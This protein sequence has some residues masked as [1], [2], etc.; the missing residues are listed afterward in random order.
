VV[1][2]VMVWTCAVL[3][4]ATLTPDDKDMSPNL[5]N[6]IACHLPQEYSRPL[7]GI[8]LEGSDTWS[9]GFKVENTSSAGRVSVYTE[10]S[11]EPGALEGGGAS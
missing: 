3:G 7:V 9:T 1:Q 10:T 11:V 4:V 6:T 8:R 2:S 5:T